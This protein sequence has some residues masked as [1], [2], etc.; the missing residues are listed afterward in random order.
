[1]TAGA[2]TQYPAADFQPKVLYKDPDYK[3]TE[4]ASSTASKTAAA[5]VEQA[6]PKAKV[7]DPNYPAADY[8]PKVLYK[9]ESYKPSKS[10]PAAASED[11]ESSDLAVAESEKPAVSKKE[12]SNLT[13]LIGLAVLA[14]GGFFFFNKRSKAKSPGRPSV[15]S[16]Y[17]KE[18]SGSTGVEKYLASL[19]QASKATGVEKY[20]ENQAKQ[21]PISGVAKY[22][23]KQI[24]RDRE[25]AAAKVTGVEKYLRSKG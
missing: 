22:V 25:A 18:S 17:A 19:P 15:S 9:D 2:E 14:L 11:Y 21:Q 10:V 20:L 3:A 5:P 23:A 4:S 12:E 16:V 6:K 8:Q 13:S 24:I 7:V 1:L